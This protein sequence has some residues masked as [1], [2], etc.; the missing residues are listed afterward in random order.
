M[1]SRIKQAFSLSSIYSIGNLIE[2]LFGIVLIPLYTTVLSSEDYGIIG[3]MSILVNITTPLIRAPVSNGF[4]RYYYQK[5]D[6]DLRKRLFF[7]SMLFICIQSIPLGILFYL[8]NQK[9]ALVLLDNHELDT[10]IKIYALIIFF[11]PLKLMV[12]SLMLIQKRAKLYV[13]VNLSRLIIGSG[14]IL[15]GLFEL[16]MGVY[17]L[18]YGALFQSVFD[19][20]VLMPYI[21]RNSKWQ[22][23]FSLLKPL[24]SYGYP[25]LPVGISLYLMQSSDRYFIRAFDSV[26]AVGL[27]T[28]A[29]QIGGVINILL[30]TP[31][32]YAINPIVFQIENNPEKVKQTLN[33]AMRYFYILALTGFLFMGAFSS[34]IVKIL[35]KK[36][37]YWE[38]W[39]IVPILSLTV[40]MV[41]MRDLFSKG[42]VMAKKP[43]YVSLSYGIGLLANIGL[44]LLLVPIFGVV[45]AALGTLFSFII[46]CTVSAHYSKRFYNLTFDLKI[47]SSITMIAILSFTVS[48]W[49]NFIDVPYAWFFKISGIILFFLML[50]FAGIIRRDDFLIAWSLRQSN[51]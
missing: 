6:F 51:P 5:E 24:L 31:L 32:K 15:Y 34:E 20:V 45:G 48:W 21:I 27:Y 47:L 9:I 35:A 33:F 25:L 46:L 38:A 17:A 10:I 13:T 14:L 37:E 18:V 12:H 4:D 28:L 49:G 11:N 8:F 44:N 43:F 50:H 40:V 7:N 22:L 1:K 2:G 26:S 39:K 29:F 36:Q 19:L 16:D 30:V 23:D 42:L 41:G 3:L